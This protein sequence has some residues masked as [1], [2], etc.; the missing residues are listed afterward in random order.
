MESVRSDSRQAYA[1]V[2]STE[3][4][5]N[6]AGSTKKHKE[7][8]KCEEIK[9]THPHRKKRKAMNVEVGHKNNRQRGAEVAGEGEKRDADTG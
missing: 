8:N 7:R 6:A 9:G 3:G 2:F 1:D 5:N 4:M